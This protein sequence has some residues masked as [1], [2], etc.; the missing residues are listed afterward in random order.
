MPRF[1]IRPISSPS[2][3]ARAGLVSVLAGLQ[4]TISIS[5]RLVRQGLSGHA[6]S[7]IA[8]SWRQRDQRREPLCLGG[9][10][11][12]SVLPGLDNSAAA[13]RPRVN[14]HVGWSLLLYVRGGCAS[15]DRA[16]D[17]AACGMAARN[18]WPREIYAARVHGSRQRQRSGAGQRI[19]SENEAIHRLIEAGLGKAKPGEPASSSGPGGAR[20]PAD[21]GKSAASIKAPE[22]KEQ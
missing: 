9:Q 8:F 21:T 13:D 19:S 7:V 10:R 14:V 20:K 5:P 6:K 12:E 3:E 2:L 22:W 18:H 11:T 4:R 1:Q 17:N 15:R 16:V